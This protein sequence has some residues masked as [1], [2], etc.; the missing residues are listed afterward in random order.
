MLAK[1]IL[2]LAVLSAL[3]LSCSSNSHKEPSQDERKAKLYY[4]HGTANLVHKDYTGALELLLKAYEIN[5]DDSKV[6]NN[7]G[8]AYYFKRS[9]EKAEEH[10]KKA[11]DLDEKNS[12]ARNNL[13]SLYFERKDYDKAQQEYQKVL[14]DLVYRHQYRTYYNLALIHLKQGQRLKAIDLLKKSYEENNDY[15]PS[16]YQLGMIYKRSYHFSEALKWFQEGSKG[17]CYSQPAPHFEQA[18]AMVNL[19]MYERASQKYRE[20]QERFPKSRYSTMALSQ[21]ERINNN[22]I[23]KKNKSKQ[24]VKKKTKGNQQHRTPAF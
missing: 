14:K 5:P 9:W 22:S 16:S 10:L 11:I 23:E 2:F 7:L 4:Q 13:A 24:I 20:I 12:D 6:N 8:M 19:E 15:C 21:L 1:R 18:E 3:A 17:T